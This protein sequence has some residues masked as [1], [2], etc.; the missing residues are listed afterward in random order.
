MQR[1]RG[2][3]T[4]LYYHQGSRNQSRG[5]NIRVESDAEKKPRFDMF[6]EKERRE[7]HTLSIEEGSTWLNALARHFSGT[8]LCKFGVS[9]VRGNCMEL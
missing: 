1:K 3:G 5:S 7:I 4:C 8:S 2:K 9:K 6:G